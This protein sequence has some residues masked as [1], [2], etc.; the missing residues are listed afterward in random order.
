MRFPSPEEFGGEDFAEKGARMFQRTYLNVALLEEFI[1]HTATSVPPDA[2][3]AAA[4]A[5]N[6]APAARPRSRFTVIVINGVLLGQQWF[7]LLAVIRLVVVQLAAAAAVR[8]KIHVGTC[9]AR[10]KRPDLGAEM[11]R[12]RRPLIDPR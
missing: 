3:T 8:S 9:D 7:A 4:A 6:R 5:V 2:T 1:A 11:R 12:Y 10:R